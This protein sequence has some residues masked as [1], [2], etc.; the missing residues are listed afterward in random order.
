MDIGDNHTLSV[1][2]DHEDILSQVLVTLGY[3]L[4]DRKLFLV[5]R[6]LPICR[7]IVD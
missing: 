1:I 6:S 3:L 2:L 5:L 7:E 4:I